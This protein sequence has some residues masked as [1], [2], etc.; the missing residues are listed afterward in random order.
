M[1]NAFSDNSDNSILWPFLARRINLDL[2]LFPGLRTSK[3]DGT[4]RY[5]AMQWGDLLW[6]CLE[7]TTRPPTTRPPNFFSAT[8]L[9]VSGLGIS[10]IRLKFDAVSKVIQLGL[11]FEG[12]DNAEEE[13]IVKPIE[14]LT[15]ALGPCSQLRLHECIV[16]NVLEATWNKLQSFGITKLIRL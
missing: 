1:K 16:K 13:R 14:K 9:T 2:Y 10:N 12:G 15:T 8:L 7:D 11:E 4:E 3:I 5:F 6:S